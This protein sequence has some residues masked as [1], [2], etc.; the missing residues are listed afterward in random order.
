MENGEY[1]K[2]IDKNDY[3]CYNLQVVATQSDNR[4][5][6]LVLNFLVSFI[7]SVVAGICVYYICKWLDWD[8]SDN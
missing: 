3:I 2:V 4:L 8:E 1:W 7:V 5:E 6:V